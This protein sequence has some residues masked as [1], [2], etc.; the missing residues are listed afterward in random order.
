MFRKT[1]RLSPW[2]P[3]KG[4]FSLLFT[5]VFRQIQ[6]NLLNNEA[7]GRI[8]LSVRGSCRTGSVVKHLNFEAE[9]KGVSFC[10][11]CLHVIPY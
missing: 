5:V 3:E 7:P 1:D 4:S 10:V 2:T 9:P 6:R 8:F 11:N